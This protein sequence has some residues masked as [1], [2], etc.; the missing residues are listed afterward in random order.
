LSVL[1]QGEVFLGRRVLKELVLK[2]DK[3]EL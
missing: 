1:V 3:S 2:M